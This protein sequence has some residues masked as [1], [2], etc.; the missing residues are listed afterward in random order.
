MN[1]YRERQYPTL[2]AL[3]RGEIVEVDGFKVRKDAG[4]IKPG[5]FYIGERNTGPHLLIAKEIMHGAVFSECRAY[6]YDL[7]ECVRV[8]EAE[9]AAATVSS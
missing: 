1:T 5:D 3:E 9:P 6:P 2:C 7:H 8:C 4:E